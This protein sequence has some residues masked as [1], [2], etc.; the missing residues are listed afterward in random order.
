M[1]ALIVEVLSSSNPEQD[2]EVK[3]DAYARAG[4]PEYWVVRPAERDVL[5][6]SQPDPTLAV[7][8]RIDPLAPDAELV[9][10]SLPVRVAVAHFFADAPDTTL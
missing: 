9:S 3:R 1:P 5:R 4:V 7:Y 10:P 6:F 8:T 2:L